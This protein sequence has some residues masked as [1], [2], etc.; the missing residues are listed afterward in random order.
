[1]P[2][3]KKTPRLESV[4]ADPPATLRLTWTDGG[5]TRVDLANWIAAGGDILAPLRDPKVFR[6]ARIGEH[7]A[8]VEWGQ[9]QDLAID[10]MH[11]EQIAAE[12]AD[13]A[14]PVRRQV[15]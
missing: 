14:H 11:L 15:R 12:Q 10:A 8:A 2:V 6:C 9:D 3:S 5:A 1:M 13:R 7:G 4:T